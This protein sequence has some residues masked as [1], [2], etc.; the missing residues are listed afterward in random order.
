MTPEQWKRNA[1]RWRLLLEGALGIVMAVIAV[2][3]FRPGAG[4]VMGGFGFL[5]VVVAFLAGQWRTH[6][7]EAMIA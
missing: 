4:A 7:Y 6:G 3:A 1:G 5:A 2:T